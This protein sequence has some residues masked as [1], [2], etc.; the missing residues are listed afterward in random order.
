M[1]IMGARSALAIDRHLDDSQNL[2][3][4]LRPYFLLV[5]GSSSCLGRDIAKKADVGRQEL[6][7]LTDT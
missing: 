2:V 3:L 5:T 6:R 7:C 1:W 4:S